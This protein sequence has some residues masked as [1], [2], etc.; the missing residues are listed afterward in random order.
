MSTK[1]KDKMFTI[2]SVRLPADLHQQLQKL[3]EADRRSLSQ[4][5]VLLVEEHI[6]RKTTAWASR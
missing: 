5:V 2:S 4:Y 3:A 6:K 1:T